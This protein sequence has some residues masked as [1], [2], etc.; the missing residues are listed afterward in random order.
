MSSA[1][2]IHAP[3]WDRNSGAG[4]VMSSPALAA[5]PS[6]GALDVDGN[7]NYDALTDG[8][9]VLRWLFGINGTGLVSGATGAGAVRTAAPDII[10]WL[11]S[12]RASLDVDGNLKTDALTD[13]LMILRYMFGLRGT[14]LT[15]GAIGAGA[16]RTTAAIEAYIPTLMP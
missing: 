8:L 3:G 1:I 9:L 5:P 10:G 16:S 14:A 4:I 15:S 7:G 13:G 12:K 6:T 11:E 2:D